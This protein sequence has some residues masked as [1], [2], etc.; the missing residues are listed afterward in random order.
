MNKKIKENM[1]LGLTILGIALLTWAI[2]S[3]ERFAW[4]IPLACGLLICGFLVESGKD[5]ES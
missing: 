4:H 5:K 1:W 2:A 3:G